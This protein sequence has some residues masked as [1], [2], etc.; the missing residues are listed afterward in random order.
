VYKSQGEDQIIVTVLSTV[1]DWTELAEFAF[2][3]MSWNG[4]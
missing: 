3:Y 1:T 4:F 2:M